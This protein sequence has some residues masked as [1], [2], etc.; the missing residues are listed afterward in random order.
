M[1]KQQREKKEKQIDV[2]CATVL[3]CIPLLLPRCSRLLILYHRSSNTYRNESHIFSLFC[4][5]ILINDVDLPFVV[6]FVTNSLHSGQRLARTEHPIKK[7]FSCRK[8]LI[9]NRAD[10]VY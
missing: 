1:V 5:S 4:A 10:F 9:V 2:N 3:S 8:N 7:K 6:L